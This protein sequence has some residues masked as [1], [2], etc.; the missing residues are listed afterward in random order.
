MPDAAPELLFDYQ[1]PRFR[2]DDIKKC[3]RRGDVRIVG[4]SEAPIPWP[5]GQRLPRG[6]ARSLVLY[7]ALTRT[8]KRESVQA[9]CYWLGVGKTTVWLWRKVLC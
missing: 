8:V 2:Y 7:G 3:A 6:R 9:V 1:T 4:L 5:I